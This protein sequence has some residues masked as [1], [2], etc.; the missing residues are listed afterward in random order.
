MEER[1][2]DD[3]KLPMFQWKITEVSMEDS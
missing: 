2:K 1:E 3:G